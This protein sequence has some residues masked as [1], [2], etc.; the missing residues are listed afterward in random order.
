MTP[1]EVF[2]WMLEN[3]TPGLTATHAQP[4][5]LDA[6]YENFTRGFLPSVDAQ[7]GVV[8]TFVAIPDGTA[9]RAE[10]GAITT[11]ATCPTP[12]GGGA[13]GRPGEG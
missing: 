12:P 1:V 7:Q 11:D 4:E 13:W 2:N 6:G 10:S 5:P 9:L 3:P 8:V